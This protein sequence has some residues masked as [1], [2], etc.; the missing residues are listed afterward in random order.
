MSDL[1]CSVN[2]CTNHKD[3]CCCRPSI[4]IDGQNACQ[5]EETCCGSFS[6]KTDENSTGGFCV[7]NKNV[8]I[9][10]S[11]QECVYNCENK[12]CS[13]H[14]DVDFSGGNTNCTTFTRR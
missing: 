2:N 14:V 4:K 12:C 3:G 1:K 8:H 9:N 13:D 11:A 5:C 6:P 7:P 10:C